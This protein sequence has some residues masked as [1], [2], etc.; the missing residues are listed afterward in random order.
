MRLRFDHGPQREAAAFDR[1]SGMIRAM[2]P[3]EVPAAL[4]AL[5]AARGQGAWLAGFAS[6]ELG[7]V[8]EER[9]LPLLPERRRLPLL[10]FGLYDGPEAAAAL[11]APQGHFYDLTPDWDAARYEQA[12]VRVRDY[13]CAGDIYQA[14]LTFPIRGGVTGTP[15]EIYAALCQLQQVKH[16]VLVEA[17]G[18]PAILSRSPEL[19]FRT[20]TSGRIETRPMKGTQPRGADPVEDAARAMFL[21]TDEKNQAENLMIVDLLR[22]DISRICDVGSVRV[23]ELFTVETY[24]TVH[25]MVSLVE[26]QLRPDTGL[27]DIFRALYPCGSITGAPKLRAMEIIAE[28]EDLPRDIYCGTIGW[29]A[30]DGRSEFNVAIRTPIVEDGQVT[31]NVG[32]GVVYDSTAASEYEEALWK[33]QYAARLNVTAS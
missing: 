31:L 14:N 9:L 32:G 28:L 15:T 5:N 19:F 27:G 8:L 6:Y 24:E 4:E 17:P 3:D 1:P 10:Q 18:L 20:D 30:P 11:P 2:T 12:F 26:G 33:A 21:K 25:Q 22:N 16:G 29:A 23:P 7:Y 13:I